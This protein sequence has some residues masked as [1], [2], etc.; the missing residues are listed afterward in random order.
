MELSDEQLEKL[1]NL[2]A[3][4]VV[5]ELEARQET[6]NEQFAIE[7]NELNPNAQ[8]EFIKPDLAS[9]ELMKTNRPNKSRL[10]LLKEE[11][12]HVDMMLS[13]SIEDEDYLE[14]LKHKNKLIDIKSLI[15]EL[16]KT[17]EE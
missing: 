16:E 17:D 9:E 6:W 7:F 10:K 11:Y 8:I 5:D 13:R 12:D 14:A 4:K 1:A 15:D 2:I 3:N